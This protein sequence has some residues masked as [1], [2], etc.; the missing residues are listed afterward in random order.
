MIVSFITDYGINT[1]IYIDSATMMINSDSFTYVHTH[2][3]MY[4]PL[5]K[6]VN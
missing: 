4:E 5:P 3:H 2:S 1:I 6:A